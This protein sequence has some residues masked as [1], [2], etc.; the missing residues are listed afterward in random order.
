MSPE[1][2]VKG[3]SER[4]ERG[5]RLREGFQV[6]VPRTASPSLVKRRADGPSTRLLRQLE[7]H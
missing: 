1:R 3:E 4:T 2:F 6:K 7:D 5:L